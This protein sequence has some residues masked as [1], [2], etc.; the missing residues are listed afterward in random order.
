MWQNT[1]K[2]S[3]FFAPTVLYEQKRQ[4]LEIVKR[5]YRK[6]KDKASDI[7]V[8]HCVVQAFSAHLSVSR[9]FRD[10]KR[11]ALATDTPYKKY[12]EALQ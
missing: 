2:P 8:N 1:R 9:S 4:P 3:C 12:N 5:S 7:L 10:V 11:T 6:K